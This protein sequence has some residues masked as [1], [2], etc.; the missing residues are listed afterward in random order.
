VTTRVAQSNERCYI[1][2]PRWIWTNLIAP[3]AVAS[4]LGAYG[5]MGTMQAANNQQDM[6][7]TE[8]DGTLKAHT[9]LIADGEL[10]AE[11]R[12]DRLDAKIDK[13]LDHLNK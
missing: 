8:H 10:R 7:L 11:K 4:C 5:W 13:I 3:L 12:F 2:L 1:G 6:K 9:E